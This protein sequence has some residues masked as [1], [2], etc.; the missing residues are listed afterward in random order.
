MDG[1][2]TGPIFAEVIVENKN[3]LLLKTQDI[4]TSNFSILMKILY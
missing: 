4:Y 3:D 2:K 1:W